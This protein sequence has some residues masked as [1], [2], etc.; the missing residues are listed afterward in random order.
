MKSIHRVI[1][2]MFAAITL[3][4]AQAQSTS[5]SSLH[6]FTLVGQ[7]SGTSA[8][9]GGRLQGAAESD[10]TGG[11]LLTLSWVKG[12][13]LGQ[14]A[15]DKGTC[16]L[17]NGTIQLTNNSRTISMTQAGMSCNVN[18]AQGPNTVTAT[19][20]VTQGTGQYQG[21]TGVGTVVV[22][23]SGVGPNTGLIRMD[24]VLSTP[25]SN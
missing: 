13:G 18:S 20:Q 3:V 16:S 22:G 10:L 23:Y 24:G 11:V 2:I 25:S 4:A 12:Q 9:D 6:L 7:G 5:S 15:G 8:G 1:T 17:Q 14:M 21:L 19:F